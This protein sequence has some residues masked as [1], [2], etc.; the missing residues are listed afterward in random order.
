MQDNQGTIRPARPADRT[1]LTAL[2]IGADPTDYLTEVWSAWLIDPRGPLLVLEVDGQPVAT[3]K[4][5][6]LSATEAWLEGLR[7]HPAYRR[8]GSAQRLIAE[9]L[10]LAHA[11][12]ARVVRTVVIATNHPMHQL[13]CGSGW[14]PVLR[15]RYATADP[16]EHPAPVRVLPADQIPMSLMRHTGSRYATDWTCCTLSAERLQ[17]HLARGEVLVHPNADAGVLAPMLD[18]KRDVSMIWGSA[19]A[20]VEVLRAVRA[21]AAAAAPEGPG[22]R[23]RALLPETDSALLVQ[24]EFILTDETLNCYELALDGGSA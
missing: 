6:L 24:A 14:R 17:L 15:V 13:L 18:D 19:A 5:T 10:A 16:Y 11:A 21:L 3:G 4:L 9:R 20:L 1:L 22:Q 8:R 7:V 12:G 2:A 23:V